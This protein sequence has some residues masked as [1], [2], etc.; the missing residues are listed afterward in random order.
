MPDKLRHMETNPTHVRHAMPLMLLVQLGSAKCQNRNVN[1][2]FSYK[3]SSSKYEVSLSQAPRQPSLPVVPHSQNAVLAVIVTAAIVTPRVAKDG[4]KE[5]ES[6]GSPR[7]DRNAECDDRRKQVDDDQHGHAVALRRIEGVDE[8]KLQVER[9]GKERRQLGGERGPSAAEAQ[10]V[11]RKRDNNR[12]GGPKSDCDGE[13]RA[14][15]RKIKLQ[16]ISLCRGR[17]HARDTHTR[18]CQ[19]LS[20]G[21]FSWYSLLSYTTAPASGTE[22]RF[23]ERCSYASYESA[24]SGS[25]RCARGGYDTR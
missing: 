15:S 25:P 1:R 12:K 13:Q 10:G 7:G 21:P 14:G 4:R 24:F 17:D 6:C 20:S 11:K 22:P 8:V 16:K 19:A 9:R 3:A 23:C 2:I 18:S 5:P